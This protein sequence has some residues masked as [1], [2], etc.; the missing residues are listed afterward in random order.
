MKQSSQKRI[1]EHYQTLRQLSPEALWNI[2]V[3]AF[4]TATPSER[5]Q[6][7]SVVR[8]VGVV[9][10]ESG[11]PKQKAD[12]LQWLGALVHDPEEKVRRYAMA[13][14]PKLG[15]GEQE[16]KQLLSLA[17]KTASARE[18]QFLAKT[19]GRIGGSETLKAGRYISTG[20][21]ALDAQR[22]RAN[23][24]RRQG[25]DCVSF[26]A[27]LPV[28]E[29]LRVA[30]DC[31]HGL[32]QIL[33]DE[34]ESNESLHS[35][36]SV[37]NAHRG[38]F[39]L[40][41]K[42]AFSLKQLYSL[43]CFSQAVF[44]LGKLPPLAHPGAPLDESALANILSSDLAAHILTHLSEGAVRYRLEFAS[45]R[46]DS[47]VVERVTQTVFN[48]RPQLL[49]DPREAPW[50]VQIHESARGILVELHPKLRPD[51]R[52]A[53]RKGDVPAASHP[54]LAAALARVADPGLFRNERIWDPFCG[55]GL[56]LAECL[57]LCK[58]AE[59]FGTDLSP[60]AVAVAETNVQAVAEKS[61][62]AGP[63]H[64]EA[65]DFR[66][67]PDRFRMRD[68]TLMLT[69]PPLGKRVPV[70]DLRV[71]VD[72]VFRLANQLL[73]D[74]G[75]LVFINPLETRPRGGRLRLT[76]R[77]KVDVGF[78]HFHLEKYVAD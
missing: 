78:A 44:L 14:L 12:A 66:A 7:V 56:E 6:N 18:T 24:A 25:A 37:Q 32:D 75:R 62:T 31:R 35:L 39:E 1:K 11:S 26:D 48:R 58:N 28:F 4:N 53:Y 57:L 22:L 42:R 72:E 55:S 27:L 33:L 64:F 36:F 40:V 54:P 59:I 70:A 5:I 60:E 41:P 49:N 45:R 67:G 77:E 34:L 51:P 47:A 63:F 52:F 23:I 38:G 8:A 73:R 71:L 19:L 13:A 21:L 69:N 65:C 74:G 61:E 68:L 16:E 20:P 3:P 30:L 17:A 29:G 2:E 10:S 15:S 76:G 9:F 46:A 43:R 50:E